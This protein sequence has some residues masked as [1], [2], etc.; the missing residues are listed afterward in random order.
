MVFANGAD[1]QIGKSTV[2]SSHRMHTF[3]TMSTNGGFTW[4]APAQIDTGN[5]NDAWEPTVTVDQTNGNVSIAW[6]DRRDDSNNVLYRTY[7]T[8]STD[9]GSTFLASQ[10]PVASAQ[11]DPRLDPNG[12]GDYMSIVATGGQAHPVWTDTSTGRPQIFTASITESGSSFTV[13][14]QTGVAGGSPMNPA[15]SHWIQIAG[16]AHDIGVGAECTA[17]VI[18]TNAVVGGF[19]LWGWNWSSPGWFTVDGGGERIT[20]NALGLP[21]VTNSIDQIWRLLSNG[22]QQL[23]GAAIDISSGA[24]G[25]LFVIGT[26]NVPGGGG[27]YEFNFTTGQWRFDNGAGERIAVGPDG[28]PWVVN[29]A[30]QIWRHTAGGWQHLPGLAHDIGIGA[31]GAAWIV[32]TNP[33]IGGFGIW[34]WNG[35]G[36]SPVEGGGTQIAVGADGL[37][38]ITNN[39]G[40]VYERLS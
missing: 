27:V 31:N 14:P 32:G 24:D 29:S 22:W 36:W 15:G 20:V 18:G 38:W 11:S 26:D 7:Y 28:Q 39:V 23:P 37:P 5:P 8:Q 9:G 12:T 21:R 1:M 19:G 17:W 4:N 33:E 6:Y 16:A 10:I 2:P 30:Q 25:S 40:G 13:P 34:R 3:F 35:S